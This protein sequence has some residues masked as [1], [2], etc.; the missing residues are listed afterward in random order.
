M[1]GGVLMGRSLIREVTLE[2]RQTLVEDSRT[3]T[4]LDD[5]PAVVSGYMRDFAVVRRKDGR[6]GDVEFA[7]ATVAHILSTHRSFKS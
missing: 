1:E 6:G 3:G 5:H 2:E 4:T 7:W